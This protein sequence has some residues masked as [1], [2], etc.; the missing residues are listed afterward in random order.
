MW[1][2]PEKVQ[3]AKDSGKYL[4]VA[5]VL[6][7]LYFAYLR[8][9]MQRISENMQNTLRLPAADVGEQ[10]G[11]AEGELLERKEPEPRGYQ[12]NLEMARQLARQ[13]PRMVANV[14]KTWV[15]GND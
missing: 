7:Y 13:E 5:A 15:S 14:V 4:L 12:K 3:I 11:L 8:P 1:Q 6:L 9:V 10:V 2:Q